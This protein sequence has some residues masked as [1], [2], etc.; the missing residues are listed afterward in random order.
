MSYVWRNQ[1]EGEVGEGRRA[2]GRGGSAKWDREVEDEEKKEMSGLWRLELHS[3][4][5]SSGYRESNE[6]LL[7]HIEELCAKIYLKAST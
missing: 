4:E 7:N 1:K 6:V 3:Y 5:P 2:G